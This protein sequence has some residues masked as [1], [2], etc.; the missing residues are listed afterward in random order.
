MVLERKRVAD[1]TI[2]VIVPRLNKQEKEKKELF[3]CLGAR[4]LKGSG[5]SWQGERALHFAKGII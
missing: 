2:S 4:G 5:I 3:F 1:A